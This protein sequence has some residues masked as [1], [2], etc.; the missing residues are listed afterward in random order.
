M[1]VVWQIP[2]EV[3]N[4]FLAQSGFQ[5]SDPRVTRLVSLAAH[6]YALLLSTGAFWTLFL[7]AQLSWRRVDDL[8]LRVP[9]RPP[10][11]LRATLPPTD[12][13]PTS[14]TMHSSGASSGSSQKRR[15]QR[16]RAAR[17]ARARC[18]LCSRQ[19]TCRRAARSMVSTSRDRPTLLISL[20][21]KEASGSYN[22][23][24]QLKCRMCFS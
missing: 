1:C 17:A 24:A 5:C 9:P 7:S 22:V 3:T 18:V 21:S 12:S 16:R 14:P 4:H 11:E 19:R 23:E 10:A 6:K 15:R 20:Q 8:L 2:D 13:S